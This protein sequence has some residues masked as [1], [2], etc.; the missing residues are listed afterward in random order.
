MQQ[1]MQITA[2][3]AE[4]A[5][6][7]LRKRGEI[8]SPARG[9]YL[10]LTPEFRQLG[11]L[12]PDYF[13][14]DL[15]QHWQQEYYVG[16]LTAALY[17]G[18]AHQQL[19]TF[20]VVVSKPRPGIHCGSVRVEF[21]TKGET[22]KTPTQQLKTRTGYMTVATPEA[23]MLD[24][25]QFMNRCGG[26]NHVATVLDE[27][28]ESVDPKVLKELL[29]KKH[30]RTVLQRLGFLLEFLG[31]DAISDVV[32]QCLTKALRVV[33][34]DPHISFTGAKRHVKWK[35]AL[36]TTIESDLDDTY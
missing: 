29:I 14:D 23:T 13:I 16:L 1:T 9:Y 7:Y 6:Y 28:V 25:I 31:H 33:P 12:P 35:V 27:L 36:N 21:I 2:K 17:F 15:M 32:Y 22:G 4:R 30:E 20:Q 10:I 26:L 24:L 19:Q 11:C 3:A 18:A 34:L 5:I 8:A